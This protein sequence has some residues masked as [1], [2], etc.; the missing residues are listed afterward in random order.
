MITILE[1][2]KQIAEQAELTRLEEMSEDEYEALPE[3]ARKLI[4]EKRLLAKR[5]KL[6]KRKELKEQQE[7]ERREKEMQDEK[8]L[9]D[10]KY[11][12]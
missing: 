6:Q 1:L 10:E 3:T 2:Q 8:R 11:A 12:P 5:E 7:Q 4:D 9:E